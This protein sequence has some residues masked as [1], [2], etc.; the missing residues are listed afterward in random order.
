MQTLQHN[1]TELIVKIENVHSILLCIVVAFLVYCIIQHGHI[2]S[3]Y[4]ILLD[5]PGVWHITNFQEISSRN[6]WL[7]V[8]N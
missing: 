5:R 6:I 3:Y 2:H 7:H 8:T 4:P 1:V